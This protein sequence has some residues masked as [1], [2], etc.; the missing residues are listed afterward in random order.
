MPDF[1]SITLNGT[2]RFK[3]CGQLTVKR[4]TC[5]ILMHFASLDWHSHQLM[6]ICLL[7]VHF[8]LS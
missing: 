2:V 7:F 3:Q 6:E 5:V 8:V 4:R 1:H